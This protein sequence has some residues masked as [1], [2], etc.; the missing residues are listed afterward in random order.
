MEIHKGDGLSSLSTRSLLARRQ[1]L[2]ARLS[3]AERLLAGSL[4]EQTRRC[5]KAGCRCADGEPHGPYIYFAP[6]TAGRGRLRYV[7]AALLDVVRGCVDTGVEV[8]AVL[9]EVSAINV[10]LLARRELG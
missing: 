1:A 2:V 4:V 6:K 7:P 10:E 3:D 5:G 8:Q 9:A